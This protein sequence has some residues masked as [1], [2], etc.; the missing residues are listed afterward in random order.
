[1]T[2]LGEAYEARRADDGP[3]HRVLA[4][5]GLLT[6][7]TLALL[8]GIVLAGT[9]MAAAWDW[10]IYRSRHVAGVL[11]GLG[12]PAFLLGVVVVLPAS[13]RKRLFV[14]LGAIIAVAGVGLF[15]FAYPDRWFGVT[16]DHLTLEVAL[17][18]AIGAFLSLWHVLSAVASFRVR[19]DP[20]GT[21]TLRIRTGGEVRTVEVDPDRIDGREELREFVD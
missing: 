10:D 6:A 14:A 18:Y 1:M 2:S 16:A 5:A 13:R 7:G 17:V 9:E 15:W 4:G 8:A 11:G 21:V 19:N 20:Q 12:V 3:S